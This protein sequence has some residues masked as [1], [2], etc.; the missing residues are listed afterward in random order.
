VIAR[1]TDRLSASVNAA[2]STD[3][4]SPSFGYRVEHRLGEA[5]VVV[6]HAGSY[7]RAPRQAVAHATSPAVGRLSGEMPV[8]EDPFGA[9][10]AARRMTI[11]VGGGARG[12]HGAGG[13]S[14]KHT[15]RAEFG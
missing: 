1:P 3:Q 10:V 11:A 13:P 12:G 5:I 8:V 4:P 15:I 6:G 9:V 7:L 14:T 2:T